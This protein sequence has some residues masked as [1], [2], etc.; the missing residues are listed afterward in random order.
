M[1][2][3][4][5]P[6]KNGQESIYMAS[7]E[8]AAVQNVTFDTHYVRAMER[9]LKYGMTSPFKLGPNTQVIKMGEVVFR[10]LGGI[11]SDEL[12]GLSALNGMATEVTNA[13]ASVPNKPSD[14][15]KAKL[16]HEYIKSQIQPIGIAN[17][18]YN[19]A[20]HTQSSQIGV[21]F[22][23]QRTLQLGTKDVDHKYQYVQ[24]GDVVRAYVPVSPDGGVSM[25][26]TRAVLQV[27]GSSSHFDEDDV[28]M[29]VWL[30]QNAKS[31]PLL[32]TMQSL[33]QPMSDIV[34]AFASFGGIAENLVIRGIKNNPASFQKLYA[35]CVALNERN[36]RFNLG[37][38]T[39]S[40]NRQR[41]GTVDVFLKVGTV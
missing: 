7:Q 30:F 25:S 2:F 35:A 32:Q 22:Y 36:K 37:V 24:P 20:D 16:V 34:K 17:S 41:D 18:D 39:S 28:E 14:A 27:D 33:L 19:P 26:N 1:A 11:R 23:G 29:L 3:Q 12:R 6:T 10:V 5:V 15:V 38:A 4:Q 8:H 40:G 31:A 21:Q 9:N 13:L